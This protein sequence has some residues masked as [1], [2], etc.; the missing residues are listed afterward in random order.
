MADARIFDFSVTARE[1]KHTG[2]AVDAFHIACAPELVAGERFLRRV[3]PVP[4]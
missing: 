3:W 1:S 4:V 2:A